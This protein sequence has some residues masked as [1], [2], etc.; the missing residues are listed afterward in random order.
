[1]LTLLHEEMAKAS[2]MSILYSDVGDYYARVKRVHPDANK[3]VGWN[4][5]SPMH[6]VWPADTD[7]GSDA[8]LDA[9]AS[10]IHEEDLQALCEY[11]ARLLKQEVMKAEG[12][13]FIV[14]PTEDQLEWELRRTKFFDELRHP[15]ARYEHS[16][17][18]HW[19]CKIGDIGDEDFAFAVWHCDIIANELNILR[20]S[21][22]S[23][24]QLEALL[25]KAQEEA[26]SQGMRLITA[27][28][29]DEKLLE[30]TGW[31][32]EMRKEHLSAVAWYGEGPVPA[33]IC[34]EVR[35]QLIK[36]KDANDSYSH[37]LQNW[38]RC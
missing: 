16:K 1:M 25:R 22:K 23:V 12:P 7:F 30:G 31:R 20:L 9:K 6:V 5:I 2:I 8:G 35:G 29:V 21:C 11:D 10:K 34:N 24:K 19:G 38:I 17:I 14:I 18:D 32:N 37:N 3:R 26:I 15:P 33:W 27:W 36:S 28:N 13:A 4:I